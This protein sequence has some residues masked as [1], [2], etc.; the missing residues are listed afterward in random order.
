VPTFHV[1]I[2]VRNSTV[3]ENDL[4]RLD[5]YLPAWTIQ[6]DCEW[7]TGFRLD[8]T[9]DAA[10]ERPAEQAVEQAVTEWLADHRISGQIVPAKV[11]RRLA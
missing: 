10:D 5:K 4:D 6:A 11:R 2:A 7:S 9:G 3:T 1:T 8:L